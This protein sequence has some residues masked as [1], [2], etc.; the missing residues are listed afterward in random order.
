MSTADASTQ[1]TDD[2]DEYEGEEG[3]SS[4]NFEEEEFRKEGGKIIIKLASMT[5]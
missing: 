1:T 3:T 2:Y 4:T 5:F